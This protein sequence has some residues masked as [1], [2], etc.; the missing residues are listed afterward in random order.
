MARGTLL[1]F[2]ALFIAAISAPAWGLFESDN[3]VAKEAKI[4]M[5]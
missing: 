4:S 3:K 2:L 5:A 1:T